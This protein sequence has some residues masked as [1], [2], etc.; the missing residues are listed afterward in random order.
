MPGKSLIAGFLEP[1]LGHHEIEGAGH[2]LEYALMAA[3]VL[4]ALG[5][6]GL[7]VFLYIRKPELPGLLAGKFA[8]I[9]RLVYRK[10]YV[11]EI[12]GLIIVEGTKALARTAAF[13]D[14]YVIDLLVNLSGLLL[15]VQSRIAGWFD[16]RFIDGMVNL[17]ADSV[18]GCGDLARRVQTGRVQA[19]ILVLL[20]AVAGGIVI[21]AI[22]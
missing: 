18:M 8:R 14:K 20:L 4:T 11:D 6:A 17:L 10:Y 19:Y 1:A 2:A 16:D 21:K 5:G 3:S 9:Y 13:F 15:R 22:I 7:A 12:Y